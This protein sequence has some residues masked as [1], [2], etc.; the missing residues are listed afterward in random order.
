MCLAACWPIPL[1]DTGDRAVDVTEIQSMIGMTEADVAKKFGEPKHR[2]GL[3]HTDYFIY[4]GHLDAAAIVMLLWVPVGIVP[5]GEKGKGLDCIRLSFE[6]GVLKGYDIE[7][8]SMIYHERLKDCRTL[9]WSAEDI[10]LIEPLTGSSMARVKNII[11]APHWELQDET[12]MYLVYQYSHP[13][14]NACVLLDFDEQYMLRR[15][16]IKSCGLFGEDCPTHRAG[17][18]AWGFLDCRQLFWSLDQLEHIGVEDTQHIRPL[19]NLTNEEMLIK[20]EKGDAAAQL[21]VYWSSTGPKRLSWL[22]RSADAGYPFAQAELAR[23]YRWGLY[24][25]ERDLAKAYLWYW[26]ANKQ[27]PEMWKLE[28]NEVLRALLS[29]EMEPRAKPIPTELQPGQCQRDLAPSSG[30]E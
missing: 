25:V 7:T 23:L 13:L 19:V 29:D 14:R 6:D 15:Y 10:E 11:G 3:N 27:H 21:Q 5:T 2:V 22:C 30:G 1:H 28:L 26:H 24:G 12:H 20:A 16:E 8:R 4:E 17:E 18:I 9:F